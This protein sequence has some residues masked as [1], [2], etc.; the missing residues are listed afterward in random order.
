MS[1]IV[2][3]A[4]LHWGVP[5]RL[6]DIDWAS[7][8]LRAYCV[9]ENIEHVVILGDLCHDR[10][11]MEIDVWNTL[12]DFAKSTRAIGQ[13]WYVFPGNHDMFLKHSW[14]INSLRPLG[15]HMTVM[16]D[17]SLMRMNDRRFY[18]LPFIHLENSY[19]R[20][21]RRLEKSYEEGDVLLTH[22]G[23]RGASL[24]T[25]F[26]LK[27]WSHV[28]FQ[29][30]KFKTVYT[31]H[32]HSMQTVGNNVFYPGSLIPFK[33]DEGDVPHG[34]FVLDLDT[35]EHQFIDV[36][37]A[38][39]ELLPD[40]IPPPAYYTILDEQLD[41][42]DPAIIRNN[43]IRVAQQ[44][45]YEMSECVK[46]RD[47]LI[48]M[49]AVSVRWLSAKVADSPVVSG[50]QSFSSF[51]LT[52]AELFDHWLKIDAAKTTGLDMG[53][54]RSLGNEIRH[55]GDERYVYADDDDK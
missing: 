18:V 39:R 45:Q 32:F 41:G 19:M 24:N 47:V 2:L 21:L 13:N 40:E 3:A 26:L 11:T 29:N 34:F 53:L 1:K 10:M 23:V 5:G 17:V 25:C 48:E 4:D 50:R 42:I 33:F 12:Y 37:E 7:R 15:D 30:S 27:D 16:E 44:R 49:G 31:G 43:M 38:G 46:M 22:I 8:A 35:M 6:R 14:Q 20:V 36:I 28:T 51:K 55:E 54:L 9:K 52:S